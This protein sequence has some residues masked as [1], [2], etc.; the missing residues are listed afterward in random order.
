ME[1]G[2]SGPGRRTAAFYR[3]KCWHYF[4]VV[5]ECKN[6]LQAQCTNCTV[7]KK[8]CRVHASY[9]KK[10]LNTEYR[11]TTLTDQDASTEDNSSTVKRRRTNEEPEV[12]I[13]PPLA[14]R[15]CLEVLSQ[16]QKLNT[17][18]ACH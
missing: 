18:K 1:E 3:W 2:P 7:S 10:H 5:E 15:Q 6:N 9:F 14:K 13:V 12:E 16:Q 17:I 11:T 8:P 4:V